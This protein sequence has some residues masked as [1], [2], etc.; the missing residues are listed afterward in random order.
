MLYR[1]QIAMS[2]RDAFAR[3]LLFVSASQKQIPRKS[4]SE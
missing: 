3:N 4:I 1:V 2:F